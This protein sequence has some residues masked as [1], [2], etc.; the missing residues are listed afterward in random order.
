MA[1]IEDE[2]VKADILLGEF[3]HDKARKK[4]NDIIKK[5]PKNARAYFGKAEASLGVHKVKAED[6]MELYKKAAELDPEEV[7]Y[8]TSLAS[9]CNEIGRFNDAEEF[10]VKATE[11]DEENAS[12]YYSEL[13]IG[14]FTRAPIAMEK[15]LDDTTTRMIK[16]K[17]LIYMLKA[18]DMNEKEAIDLLS[19]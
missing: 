10:Y 9:F 5:D 3:E 11:I 12:L 13:A 4:F 6:I 16:K 14:Y 1:S 18:L 7:Y 19:D 2:L 15:F 8:V 17:S